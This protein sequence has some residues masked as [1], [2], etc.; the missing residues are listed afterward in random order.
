M[1]ISWT[2][3]RLATAAMTIIT[4]LVLSSG[5]AE[6]RPNFVKVFK[7][8]YPDL[9]RT[10]KE[11]KAFKINCTVCHPAKDNKKK[12]HRNNYGVALKEELGTKKEKDTEKIT[13]ALNT[14]ESK[15]SHVNGKEFGDL[16]KAGKLPGKDEKAD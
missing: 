3:G 8:T 14:I 6:A 9:V 4:V 1:L 15:K 12:K 16:I 7:A 11:T 2:L 5:R 10:A 13:R